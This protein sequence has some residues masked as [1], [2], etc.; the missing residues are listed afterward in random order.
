[1]LERHLTRA[2]LDHRLES[3]ESAKAT[4][5]QALRTFDEAKFQPIRLRRL[6]NELR[7]E[8]LK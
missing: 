4:A 2:L 3:N 6:A 1:V 7:T 8:A 5:E